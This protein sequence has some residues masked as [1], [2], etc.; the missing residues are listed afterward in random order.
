MTKYDAAAGKPSLV[1]TLA[2]ERNAYEI[3]CCRK[4]W[5]VNKTLKDD[6]PPL[7]ASFNP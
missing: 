3:E 6:N 5:V 7:K 4:T 1:P 2:A